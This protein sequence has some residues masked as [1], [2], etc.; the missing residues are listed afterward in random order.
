MG[1]GG[2]TFD[3]ALL[4]LMTDTV[5]I[6]PFSSETAGRVASYGSAVSY[7]AQI[8]QST[9][10]I[11]SKTGQEIVS[12]TQVVIPERVN[13]DERSLLTLPSGFV[14]QTPPIQGVRQCGGAG[15]DL[16]HTVIYL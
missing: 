1:E 7:Q 12:Q 5:T 14:P 2:M 10:R 13:V 4:D 15:L 16:D 11:T 8:V 9:Q 3:S 6:A